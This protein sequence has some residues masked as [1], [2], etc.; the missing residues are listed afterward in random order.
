MKGTEDF[1]VGDVVRCIDGTVDDGNK[2][3]EVHSIGLDP[4]DLF[5]RLEPG[6]IYGWSSW[7]FERVWRPGDQFEAG[8]LVE[9]IHRDF[10]FGI[11]QKGHQYTVEKISTYYNGESCIYI[12]S[13]T[14]DSDRFKL[15]DR[16]SITKQSK[17]VKSTWPASELTYTIEQIEPKRIFK[18]VTVTINLKSFEDLR[19]LKN[20]IGATEY[21][22]E[23][24]CLYTDLKEIERSYE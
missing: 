8:D 24:S 9:R 10:L 5:L 4:G 11:L 15:I 22:P 6:D 21:T 3:H 7:R 2:L 23:L 16:P 13:S 19:N 17:P 12:G 20:G 14:Y 1:Q 18:P